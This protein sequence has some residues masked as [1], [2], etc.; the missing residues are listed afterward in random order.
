M[1]LLGAYFQQDA[2]GSN[3]STLAV[4]TATVGSLGRF[5]SGRGGLIFASNIRYGHQLSKLVQPVVR[6]INN[7]VFARLSIHCAIPASVPYG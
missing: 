4:M 2:T 1:T 3:L 7:S 5:S 6:A